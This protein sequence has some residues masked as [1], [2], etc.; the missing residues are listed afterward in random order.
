VS[1]VQLADPLRWPHLELQLPLEPPQLVPGQV[2]SLPLALYPVQ[3]GA[4]AQHSQYQHLSYSLLH[5]WALLL[6]RLLLLLV[7]V[8]QAMRDQWGQQ[9]VL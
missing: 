8:T 9:V 2:L 6:L 3:G 1:Q 7:M 4:L 5:H